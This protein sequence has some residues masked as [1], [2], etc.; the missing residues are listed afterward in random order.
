[1]DDFN[2]CLDLS[3]LS[4]FKGI[5]LKSKKNLHD[6]MFITIDHRGE[7]RIVFHKPVTDC[8]VFIFNVEIY[9]FILGLLPLDTHDLLNRLSDVEN[10]VIVSKLITLDLSEVKHV[11]DDEIHELSRVLLNFLAFI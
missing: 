11:L 7:I 3:L 6:P 8:N 5:S 10:L 2:H 4:E 1:M 9:I